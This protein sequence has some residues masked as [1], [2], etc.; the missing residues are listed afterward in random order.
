MKEKIVTTST[1]GLRLFLGALVIWS[2]A[3]C[4]KKNGDAVVLEKEH[5]AIRE[6]SPTPNA[7]SSASPTEATESATEPVPGSDESTS[8][9]KIVTEL[10]EDEID[11]DGY[12]MKKD[13][14]G[15]SKDP[16]AMDYERWIVKVQMIAD[17]RRLDVQTDRP[18]WEK[19]KIGDRIKVTYRQ[20]KYTG[21][22]WDADID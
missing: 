9:E 13:V 7:E 2:A 15:T 22:V 3:G 11:V 14:R 16:R 6:A 18:R 5:I 8:S 17:L 4:N 10:H 21:T 12:V 19:V 20:G 1:I